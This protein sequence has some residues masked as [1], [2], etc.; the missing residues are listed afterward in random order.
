MRRAV[1]FLFVAASLAVLAWPLLARGHADR[2][3]RHRWRCQ[4]PPEE[5]RVTLPLR[6]CAEGTYPGGDPDFLT[7]DGSVAVDGIATPLGR[8]VASGN[9][10]RHGGSNPFYISGDFTLTPVGPSHVGEMTGIYKGWYEIPEPFAGVVLVGA[11]FRITGGTGCFEGAEGSGEAEGVVEFTESGPVLK[12]R[13]WGTVTV[14]APPRE[15]REP[16]EPR[17]RRGRSHRQCRRHRHGDDGE[18]D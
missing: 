16:R 4:P 8:F 17:T 1:L 9:V 7:V 12:L 11:E 15:P 6:G 2:W 10:D 13:F 18:D 5:E 3:P 14:K